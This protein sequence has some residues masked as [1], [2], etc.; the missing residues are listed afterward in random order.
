MER[1]II[2]SEIEQKI[3]YCSHQDGRI[4]FVEDLKCL[5]YE[6]ERIMSSLE[7]LLLLDFV[8]L[9]CV[10]DDSDPIAFFITNEANKYIYEHPELQQISN[11]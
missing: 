10:K 7:K 1:N 4:N 9:W 3:L 11:N 2:L 5:G 8:Y 6:H